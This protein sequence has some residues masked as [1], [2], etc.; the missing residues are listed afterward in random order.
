MGLSG[1][2][3]KDVKGEKVTNSR[4]QIVGQSQERKTEPR[5]GR[6]IPF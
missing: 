4:L 6:F 3:G 5:S 2:E 1:S